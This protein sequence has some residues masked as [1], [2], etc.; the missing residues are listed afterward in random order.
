MVYRHLVD[1]VRKNHTAIVSADPSDRGRDS[2][3][4]SNQ[5]AESCGRFS[6]QDGN[7]AGCKAGADRHYDPSLRL[8]SFALLEHGFAYFLASCTM[9]L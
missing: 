5:C 8:T 7:Y 6:H 9:G 4:Y 3:H 2:L 1:G